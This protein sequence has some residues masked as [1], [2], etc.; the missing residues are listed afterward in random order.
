YDVKF[1]TANPPPQVSTAQASA[2]Y[3]PG[4]L[5]NSR[6]YFWQIVAHNNTGTTTGPVWSFTTGASSTP[7]NIVIYASDIPAANRHGA[8]TT[9]SDGTAAAGTKLITPDNG[10]ANTNTALASPTDYVDVTF[11]AN[12]G[13]PYT[14]WLR[15]QALGNSKFNDSLWVQFSDAQA[16]GTGIYG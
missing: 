12:A 6:Q 13:T 4:T 8:W 2:S 7:A 14:V 10:V 3:S 15:L 5:Q 1:G 9:G 11:N 16:A